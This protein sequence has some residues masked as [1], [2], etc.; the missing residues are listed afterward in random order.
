MRK[1][2]SPTQIQQSHKRAYF[3]QE[4]KV[5]GVKAN[6]ASENNTKN[7]TQAAKSMLKSMMKTDLQQLPLSLKCISFSKQEQFSIFVARH[8]KKFDAN[9]LTSSRV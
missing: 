4:S 5:Y 1:L 7:Y 6:V 3:V 8:N 2:I 9:I